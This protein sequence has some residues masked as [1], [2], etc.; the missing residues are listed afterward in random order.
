MA[1]SRDLA[2]YHIFCTFPIDITPP[3]EYNGRHIKGYSKHAP[4]QVGFL[5][6]LCLW[7]DFEVKL[8]V[9]ARSSGMFGITLKVT[10]AGNSRTKQKA[11]PLRA[12]LFHIEKAARSSQAALNLQGFFAVF[13]DN[14][15]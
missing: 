13:L 12:G 14:P 11:D 9:T 4:K 8:L 6:I 10:A 1:F 15:V 3:R 2:L 5:K 7:L